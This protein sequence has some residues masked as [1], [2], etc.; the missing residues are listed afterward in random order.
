MCLCSDACLA[1]HADEI[2]RNCHR[3]S[4]LL[5]ALAIEE[6]ILLLLRETLD[7]SRQISFE[8]DAEYVNSVD[9]ETRLRFELGD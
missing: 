2:G 8:E 7:L 4:L 1:R 3:R 5:A 9:V 6:A